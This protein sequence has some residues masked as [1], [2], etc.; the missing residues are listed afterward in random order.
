[1]EIK[2]HRTNVRQDMLKYFSD[3]TILCKNIVVI[4][5]NQRGEEEKGVGIGVTRDVFSMFWLDVCDSLM[6]GEVERVPS[7]RHDYQRKEWEAIGR[8]LLN[9]YRTCQYFPLQ[10][11]K[12]FMTHCLFGESDITGEMLLQ[13][14]KHF[15]SESERKLIENCISGEVDLAD[16]ALIDLLSNFECKKVITKGNLTGTLKEIAHKEMIQKPQ[17]VVDCWKVIIPQLKAFFPTQRYLDE[18]YERLYPTCAKVLACITVETSSEAEKECLK[19]LKRYIRGLDTSKLTKFLRFISG[20]DI[21]LFEHIQISF[22]QLDGA[23]RRPIAHTCNFLLELP[24]TY[25]SF[26]ELREEFNNILESN[27]WEIDII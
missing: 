26:P 3:P 13:S 18:L 17:Y 21:M 11:S 7:I 14:F 12:I 8:I 27:S 24:S 1:M 15:V 19:H 10:V 2:I 25:Q 20:S 4:M 23:Q 6:I 5:I 16:D 22:T 9:G